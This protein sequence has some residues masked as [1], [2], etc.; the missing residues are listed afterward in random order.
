MRGR[1]GSP[2]ARSAK[3]TFSRSPGI[4]N[5]APQHNRAATSG[6]GS[7]GRL[8]TARSSHPA[9][10]PVAASPSCV[11][12][13]GVPATGGARRD[14]DIDVVGAGTKKRGTKSKTDQGGRE[15]RASM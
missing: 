9:V 1:N 13:A 2:P 12:G 15:W 3:A 8:R 7:I 5:R 10:R 6:T 4:E 14:D 11:A